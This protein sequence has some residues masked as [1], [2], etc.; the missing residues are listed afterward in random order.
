MYPRTNYEMSEE[1]LK[2]ISDACKPVPV[3]LLGGRTPMGGTQQ[4]NANLAWKS[5]GEK[6]GF[7][8]ETVQP[9]SGKGTR[10]FSA[11]PSE[12]ETQ[13]KERLAGEKE[14]KRKERISTLKGEIMTRENELESLS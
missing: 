2:K 11:I 13:M 12:T 1:D 3:L 5:L 4:D 14:T 8:S 10:H 9:L 6:M 7:E